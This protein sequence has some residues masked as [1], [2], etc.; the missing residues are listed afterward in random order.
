M[1]K[2]GQKPPKA[3]NAGGVKKS[4]FASVEAPADFKPHFLL[5]VFRTESDGLI[6][7][8]FRA[9]R[10][11]GRFNRDA[12]EKKKSEMVRYDPLTLIGIASRMG[13]LLY[14]TTGTKFFSSSVKERNKE[15]IK[16]AHRLP[17]NT[18]FQALCRV[19][20]KKDGL[21]SVSIKSVFQ[22]CKSEKT[23][24]I[25]PIELVKTDPV[26]RTVRRAGKFLPPAF[27]R[28]LMPPKMARKKK[29]DDE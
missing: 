7:A 6:G 16:G 18:V 14:K 17:R 11:K 22:M 12:E 23:G 8:D 26:S 29:G 13:A 5:L 27:K 24:K 1:F 4:K 25:K 3:K 15:K 9:V 2:K 20:K 21:I 10:Y 19:S 28:V